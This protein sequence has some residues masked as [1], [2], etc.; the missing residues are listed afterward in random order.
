MAMVIKVL[1][2]VYYEWN[3]DAPVSRAQRNRGEDQPQP[4]REVG[5]IAQ[6]VRDVLPRHG[7]SLLAM[8]AL[9]T[10]LVH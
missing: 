4:Q 2:P 1:R 9:A 8:L 10:L 5:F 3:F 7:G 6:E